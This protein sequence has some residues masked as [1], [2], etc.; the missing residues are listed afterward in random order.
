MNDPASMLRTALSYYE[1]LAEEHEELRTQAQMESMRT[2]ELET[3]LSSLLDDVRA[4]SNA[5]AELTAFP[6]STEE[7]Q[8]QQQFR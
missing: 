4:E 2:Q 7:E 5:I 3:M 1:S 6:V 8:Q